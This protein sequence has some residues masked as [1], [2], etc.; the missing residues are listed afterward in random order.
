MSK[1]R[2][3]SAEQQQSITAPATTEAL[4]MAAMADIAWT[5]W[6]HGPSIEDG[7]GS[8]LAKGIDP[9]ARMVFGGGGF[10]QMTVI[11]CLDREAAVKLAERIQKQEILIAATTATQSSRHGERTIN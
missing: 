7:F 1:P 10:A 2:R 6:P 3:K 9:L 11:P 8:I 4:A 5:A